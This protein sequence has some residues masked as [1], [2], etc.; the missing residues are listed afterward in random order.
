MNIIKKISK[1][2]IVLFSATMFLIGFIFFCIWQ[3]NSITIS[4]FDYVNSKIP[5][6]FNDFTIAHISDLHNK[7]FGEN[8]VKLLNKVKSISPDI[9]VITGD[10]IDR[11]KYDLDTAIMF[12]SGAAKIAPIY[13]VSGNHEA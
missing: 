6:E 2:I 12:A 7:M 4:K 8:Q 3:N 5:N 11:R 9:I 13:Y 10:L 1:R